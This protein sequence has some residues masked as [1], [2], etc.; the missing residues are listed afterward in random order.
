MCVCIFMYVYLYLYTH[1]YISYTLA[2]GTR[3]KEAPVAV[4][5]PSAQTSV[6]NTIPTKA[7][8]GLRR[9]MA[10][11]GTWTLWIP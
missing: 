10:D 3:N 2:Q 8:P 1:A 6:S 7:A 5:A 4:S 11:S 9:D